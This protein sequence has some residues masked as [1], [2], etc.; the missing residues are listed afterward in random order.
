MYV[1]NNT[2]VPENTEQKDENETTNII[3]DKCRICSNTNM[4]IN[5]NMG[6]IKFNSC[7]NE[8]DSYKIGKVQGI[9]YDTNV[10]TFKCS[11]CGAEF[12]IE[13]SESNNVKCHW[14]RNILSV[15]QQITNNNIPDEVLPFAIKKE[16]AKIEIEKILE[17]R[18]FF[19]HPKFIQE[20]TPDNIVGVYFPYMIVDINA[21]AN[22]FGQGEHLIR[23]YIVVDNDKKKT[24]YDADLYDIQRD[25]DLQIKGFTIDSKYDKKYIENSDKL[26]TNINAIMPF[27]IENSVKWNSN[28]LKGYTAEKKDIDIEDFKPSIEKQVKSIAKSSVNNTLNL[29]DRGISWSNEQLYIKDEQWKSIYLPVWLYSYYQKIGDGTFLNYVAVNARTKKITGSIPVYLPKLT[30]ISILFEIFGIILMSIIEFNY[31]WIFLSF[32]PVF[33]III[34]I[35]YHNLSTK[36]KCNPKINS[37]IENLKTLDKFVTRK[38]GLET[39]KISDTNNTKIDNKKFIDRILKKIRK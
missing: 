7:N 37:K 29:Y 28:Y 25:F 3:H 30:L 6:Q 39:T 10:L 24:H 4:T 21:H 18:N 23:K 8:F 35:R 1:S 9:V 13:Q 14:C 11:N 27:D 5:S 2:I 22:L 36:Y 20:F 16:E 34:F 32:G 31:N 19:A 12:I 33:F 26:T 17:K 15:D 38:I